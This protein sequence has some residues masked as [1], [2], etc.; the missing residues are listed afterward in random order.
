MTLPR[1]RVGLSRRTDP[2]TRRSDAKPRRKPVLMAEVSY[3]FLKVDSFFVEVAYFVQVVGYFFE[4]VL[5]FSV[6]TG[7]FRQSP[8]WFFVCV[9]HTREAR[10]H[11][12]HLRNLRFRSNRP[13]RTIRIFNHEWTRIQTN[14]ECANYLT[15]GSVHPIGVYSCPFVVK[16]FASAS[17]LQCDSGTRKLF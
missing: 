4:A 2:I 9:R 13:E 12:C 6:V 15:S 16:H 14:Q 17:F 3:F 8:R 5:N 7:H 1:G 11:R 10:P